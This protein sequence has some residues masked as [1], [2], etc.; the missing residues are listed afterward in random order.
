VRRAENNC[1]RSLLALFRFADQKLTGE[2][3]PVSN[4][5]WTLDLFDPNTLKQL[6]V[7]VG[8]G[9]AKGAA[10]GAGIDLMVGGMSLGLA[11]GLGALVGAT[12]GAARRHGSDLAA[13]LRGHRFLC[14]DEPTLR[15]IW[16]RQRW[17][18][19]TLDTRGH[20]SQRALAIKPEQMPAMPDA[21]PVWI[22]LLR[23]HPDW[24]TLS[25]GNGPIDSI[26]AGLQAAVRSASSELLQPDAGFSGPKTRS[27]L[28]RE[29]VMALQGSG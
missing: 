18:L 2:V 11:T 22:K 26:E 5:L 21:W 13:R 19:E 27:A 23:A 4:G 8:A 16:L 9:A 24:S 12:W 6:G 7:D 10:I 15:A 25:V 1:A 28:V 14:V 20:A 17:L 3:L 29:M